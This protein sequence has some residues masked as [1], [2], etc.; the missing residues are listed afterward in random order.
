MAMTQGKPFQGRHA[1]VTG[2]GRGIG[3]AIADHLAGLGASITVMGRTRET[4]EN[5]AAA[6]ESAHG[7]KVGVEVVDLAEPEQIERGFASAMARLGPAAILVNNAGIAL[8]APFLKTDLALWNKIFAVDATAPF[9]CTRQVL[10]GMIDAGFGRVIT[11]S[12]T[13][14]LTG[15]PYVSAYC[16]AKHAVVG[17]TRALAREVA[18]TGVTV[19]CVCPGYTDTDIVA[20]ALDNIA[21][22]TGRSRE[23]A[24]ADIVSHNPQGRLIQPGEVAETVGWLCRPTSLSITGQ[25][26]LIA[27]GELM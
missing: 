13:A 26:I 14:G 16:A 19:N 22:K 9:L 21:A 2:G 5:S 18:K 25:S 17:M 24:L 6:I 7:V 10:K 15:F 23:D 3:A 4:L 12:S 11:V 20:G 27:G 1:V 8:P